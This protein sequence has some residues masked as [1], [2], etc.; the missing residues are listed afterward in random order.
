LFARVSA[1]SASLFGFLVLWFV[2]LRK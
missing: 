2:F 1:G